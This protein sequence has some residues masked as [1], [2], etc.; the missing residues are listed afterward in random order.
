MRR[1]SSHSLSVVRSELDEE[2]P[3]AVRR[4]IHRRGEE[5]KRQALERAFSRL[6]VQ[7]GLTL[8]QQEI[9]EN[10][11]SAIVDGILSAPDSML[12]RTSVHDEGTVRMAVELFDPGKRR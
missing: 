4:A 10:M 8:K 11:A 6:A 5:L 2:D 3:E 7:G 1:D 12:S 9:L